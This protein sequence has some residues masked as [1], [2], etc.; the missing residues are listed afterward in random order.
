MSHTINDPAAI[1]ASA[2]AHHRDG[3]DPELIELPESAVFPHLIPAQ[4]STARKSRVTGTLLGKPTPP[5]VKRGRSV[6]YRLKDVL[7]WLADGDAY[8]NTAEA[9][10]AGGAHGD[11]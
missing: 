11:A 2:L 7:D 6:R 8:G 4:P 5:F 10:L 9:C 3:L 1:L